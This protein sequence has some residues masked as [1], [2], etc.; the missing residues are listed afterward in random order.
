MNDV[1]FIRYERQGAVGLI[2]LDRPDTRNAQNPR[3]LDELDAAW[4][5]GE[6]DAGARVLVLRAN[7][8][9]FSA[10]HD[11]GE[12]GAREYYAEVKPLGPGVQGRHAWERHKYLGYSLRWRDIPKPTIAAVQG[13]CIAGGLMLCWPCDLIVAADD[14]FFSD[15]VLRMGIAGVE[16]H[17]HTWELGARKAKEWLFTGSRIDAQE[18][19]RLGMVNRVVPREKLLE[20]TLALAGQIAEMPPFALAMTKRA[21]NRTLDA[22]GFRTALEAVFDMHQLGHAHGE[23]SGVGAGGGQTVA[24]MKAS[25]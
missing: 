17:A 2:T 18:A 25:R 16:Y 1:R 4:T 5:L 9:H 10:G 3:F 24:S 12:Q 6:Q 11:I 22:Q 19:L 15:P 23:L 7:G 21:V 8:K 13:A 20:E 14:A